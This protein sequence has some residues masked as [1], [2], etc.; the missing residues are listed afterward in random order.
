MGQSL[1]SALKKPLTESQVKELKTAAANGG[2]GGG[3]AAAAP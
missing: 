1:E 2:D 3:G